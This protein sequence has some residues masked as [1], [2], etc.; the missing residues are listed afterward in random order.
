METPSIGRIVHYVLR[1]GRSA[2]EHRPAIIVRVW[3]P[4]A[5]YVNLQV[6]TDGANDGAEAG[7]GMIWA[8]SV[9]PDEQ[10][11]GPGTWH[12]PERV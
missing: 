12:W 8:T 3:E 5:G 7:S 10:F 6:L 1:D 9:F 11:Q 2:G 4:E